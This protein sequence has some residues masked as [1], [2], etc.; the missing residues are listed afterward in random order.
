MM[1]NDQDSGIW[2][3]LFNACA[4]SLHW[5]AKRRDPYWPGGMDYGKLNVILFCLILPSCW[6]PRQAIGGPALFY[7]S[8]PGNGWS[9]TRLPLTG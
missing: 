8:W 7:A 4:N 6:I 9:I 2:H 5:M 1:F 3:T